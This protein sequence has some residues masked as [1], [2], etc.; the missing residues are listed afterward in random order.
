MTSTDNS[1]VNRE[2]YVKTMNK[3]KTPKQNI[4]DLRRQIKLLKKSKNFSI[5]CRILGKNRQT[6]YKQQKLRNVI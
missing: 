4:F 3:T 1:T 2:L 5:G 6:Y